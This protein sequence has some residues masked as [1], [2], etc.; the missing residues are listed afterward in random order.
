MISII[1]HPGLYSFTGQQKEIYSTSIVSILYVCVGV[2]MVQS[3]SVIVIMT[4]GCH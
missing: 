3:Q 4:N 2:H 1:R